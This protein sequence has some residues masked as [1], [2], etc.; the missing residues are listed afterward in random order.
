[1]PVCYACLY[2]REWQGVIVLCSDKS[3]DR[4]CDTDLVAVLS[5]KREVGAQARYIKAV[6]VY[7][8]V[9]QKHQFEW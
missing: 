6:S 4:L 7:P 2:V 9:S 8:E 5:T 3:T 1:M